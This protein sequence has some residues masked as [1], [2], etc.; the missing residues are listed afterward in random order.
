[1]DALIHAENYLHDKAKNREQFYHVD[2]RT[3]SKKIVS[4]ESHAVITIRDA[5]NIISGQIKV[6]KA[7]HT[8]LQ[9][10]THLTERQVRNTVIIHVP[11]LS[12][13][14]ASVSLLPMLCYF[15]LR[16]ARIWECQNVMALVQDHHSTAQEFAEFLRLEPIS[17]LS[18]LQ[19]NQKTERVY[20]QRLKYA[21]H[22]A[23]EGC[24]QPQRD[25]I[26][27]YFISEILT[28]F[29]GWLKNFFQESW[30]S[31]VK[32]HTMAYEQYV[33]SLY[34]LHQFVKHTTR[35]A[36]RCVALCED[37]ELRN[38]Y[39]HHLRGEINH[40]IIIESDLKA[41]NADVEFLL[42]THVPHPATAEFMTLQESVIGFKQ[43]PILMLACPFVAEGMTA[44]ISTIFVDDLYAT[45][46]KW[47][48]E[49]PATVSRF[50]TS[51]MKT[52]GGEDGHWLRVIMMIDKFIKTENHHQQ[53]LNI[54]HLAMNSYAHGLN[55]NVDDL[56]LW[57]MDPQSAIHLVSS[58][59]VSV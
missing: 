9:K 30:F 24:D 28:L 48:V 43:D 49:N 38:H 19:I 8:T 33:C 7:S 29:E 17:Y 31:S 1:M 32:S 53:F 16:Q 59:R 44:N 21:I 56:E 13:I 23:Y 39:I 3:D 12:S 36:A 11:T 54:L 57:R 10:L 52:D 37:R 2:I 25:F 18:P 20:A 4:D 5:G 50:L 22:H 15:A 42:N 45:I 14:G 35:L 55:A 27:T 26:Q 40:E 34:N 58:E 46:K 6:E 47:G 51:H 41:L